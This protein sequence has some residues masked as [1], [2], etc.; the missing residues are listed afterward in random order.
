[1]CLT[2]TKTLMSVYCSILT[3]FS[4][5][6]WETKRQTVKK[7]CWKR[8]VLVWQR[9]WLVSLSCEE[10][11]LLYIQDA[12]SNPTH[13]H[14]LLINEP[15]SLLMLMSLFQCIDGDGYLHD[16]QLTHLSTPLQSALSVILV[17]NLLQFLFNMSNYYTAKCDRE[18]S[19]SLEF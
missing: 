14:P 6:V 3:L 18:N 1:M 4:N 5:H 7:F 2:P 19:T 12:P 17:L 10:G 13:P 16:T 15:S 8:L 11:P 9:S